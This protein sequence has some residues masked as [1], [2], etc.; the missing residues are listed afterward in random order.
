M[1]FQ[2]HSKRDTSDKARWEKPKSIKEGRGY[3]K[4]KTKKKDKG[5]VG[6]EIEAW[7]HIGG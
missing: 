5:S 7:R 6:I 2:M 3:M 1:L 4:K